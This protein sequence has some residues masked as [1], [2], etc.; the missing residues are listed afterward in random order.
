MVF[1]NDFDQCLWVQHPTT[2]RNTQHPNKHIPINMGSLS[3]GE[4]IKTC[5]DSGLC[6]KKKRCSKFQQQNK[7]VGG[8]ND[9]PPRRDNKKFIVK[10]LERQP[11]HSPV[12]VFCLF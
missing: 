8:A 7:R 6:Q 9:A 4:S 10:F 1:L 12:L 3:T 5:N 2:G 11:C